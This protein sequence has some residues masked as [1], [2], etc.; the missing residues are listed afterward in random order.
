MVTSRAQGKSECTVRV[1]AEVGGAYGRLADNMPGLE[2]MSPTGASSPA[3]H[4]RTAGPGWR[5]RLELGFV[6]RQGRTVLSE[7]ASRGPL[8]VQRPFTPE[9]PEFPHV[10]ILHPPGGI[11]GGDRLSLRVNVG[12]GAAA[13]CTTPAAGKFYRSAGAESRLRQDFTVGG[14]LEWLPQETILFENAVA[15]QETIVRLS[16]GAK[17]MGWD[18]TCAGRPASGEV[19]D[20][21]LFTQVLRLVLSGCIVLNERMVLGRSPLRRALY[22]WQSRPV[23]GTFI[24][25]GPGAGELA[26]EARKLLGADTNAAISALPLPP[27]PAS[28]GLGGDRL[29]VARYLGDSVEEARDSFEALRGLLRP[30]VFA[31]EAVRPAIWNT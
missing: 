7:R 6:A 24:C 11:V 14:T 30:R 26:T 3:A 31:R 28:G 20:E 16:S 5:A 9:G 25:V 17:Y 29:L 12:P 15:R 27:D 18:I 4:E 1:E 8:V 23:W 2:G 13:L 19:F 22:G 10:Y 21:G